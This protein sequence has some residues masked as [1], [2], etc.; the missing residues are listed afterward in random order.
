MMTT[1]T[2]SIGANTTTTKKKRQLRKNRSLRSAQLA[3]EQ[4]LVRL[5]SVEQ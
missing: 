1:M 5:P 4:H 3:A 2:V